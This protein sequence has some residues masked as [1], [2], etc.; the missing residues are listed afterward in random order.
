MRSII[1]SFKT[2]VNELL[3]IAFYI[4]RIIR[5]YNSQQFLSFF[6]FTR[7]HHQK[8]CLIQYLFSLPLQIFAGNCFLYL[9]F[10]SINWNEHTPNE[11]NCFTFEHKFSFTFF[12]TNLD[13]RK[14]NSKKFLA[15]FT[16][17]TSS[18]ETVKHLCKQHTRTHIYTSLNRSNSYIAQRNNIWQFCMT[19]H[20]DNQH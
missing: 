17:N 20:C 1:L 15:N 13:Y 10:R 19:I 11:T 4:L 3:F 18:F 12:G 6:Y 9:N 14:T 7:A 5:F 16:T 8:C 2:N